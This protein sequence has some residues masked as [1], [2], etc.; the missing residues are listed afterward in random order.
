MVRLLRLTVVRFVLSAILFLRHTHLAQDV[1]MLKLSKIP[2]GLIF[3]F[4]VLILLTVLSYAHT[5]MLLLGIILIGAYLVYVGQKVK[6]LNVDTTK[7]LTSIDKD[8]KVLYDNQKNTLVIINALRLEI[9]KFKK[10]KKIETR[11]SR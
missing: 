11:Q 6:T 5:T 1:N 4:L 8:L 10:T 2:F 3:K 9:N 7:T